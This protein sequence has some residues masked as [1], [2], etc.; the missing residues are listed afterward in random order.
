MTNLSWV[1]VPRLMTLYLAEEDCNGTE[2]SAS[3]A[4]GGP[5]L[6]GMLAFCEIIVRNSIFSKNL[7]AASERMLREGVRSIGN[8]PGQ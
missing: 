7:H 8:P 6:G 2:S 4:F 5:D 1:P 3:W